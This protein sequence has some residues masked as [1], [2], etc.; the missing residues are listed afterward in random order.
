MTSKIVLTAVAALALSLS[1]ALAQEPPQPEDASPMTQEVL[2][3]ASGEAAGIFAEGA[4]P[5]L[6]EQKS[7]HWL[8][9]NVVGLEVTN[10]AGET[11]GEVAALEIDS[12][13][14]VVG[15]V[16]EAGGFLGLG[17]KLIGVP[18]EAVE[19]TRTDPG[20]QK[21][22]IKASQDQIEAAPEFLT[23]LQVLQAEEAAKARLEMEQTAPP[24]L[25]EPVT[26]N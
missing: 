9:S 19:H 10:P 7:D 4:T 17:T 13:G 24:A 2:P 15:V 25:P 26:G 23:R 11:L 5:F 1:P 3:E 14:K 16:I 22:V 21:L 20:D 8:T 6:A 12:E 18:Y